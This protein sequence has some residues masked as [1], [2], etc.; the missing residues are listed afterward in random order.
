LAFDIIINEIYNKTLLDIGFTFNLI[1]TGSAFESIINYL[2]INKRE[3][4]IKYICIFCMDVSKYLPLKEKYNKITL[5]SKSKKD[6]FE[7]FINYYSDEKNKIFPLERFITYEEYKKEFFNYHLKISLYYGNLSKEFYLAN[8]EK[9]NY[10][11]KEDKGQLIINEEKLLKSFET[12]A[13]NDDLN[14]INERI[15]K[16]STKNTFFFDLNRWLRNLKKYSNEEIAYFTS[17]FMYSLNMYGIQNNKYLDQNSIVYRVISMNL[18]SLLLYERAKG[19]IIIL[20]CFI[21]IYIN[22][23]RF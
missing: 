7:N 17:R 19:K 12:F 20:K 9:I 23:I 3:S 18:S 6:V 14:C 11:M 13:L 22:N 10:L 21:I 8:L 15:I 4:C 16:E 2:I 5:I 1:V